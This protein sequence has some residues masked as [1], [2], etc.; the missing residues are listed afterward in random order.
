[1]ADYKASKIAQGGS[2]SETI[3]LVPWTENQENDAT[4]SD[5]TDYI[6]KRMEEY[7]VENLNGG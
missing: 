3:E 2:I 5:N 6:N 4:A 7:E 1:M